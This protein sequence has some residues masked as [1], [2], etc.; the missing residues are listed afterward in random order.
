MY[1]SVVH[2]NKNYKPIPYG[3]KFSSNNIFVNFSNALHTTKILASKNLVFYSRMDEYRFN[4][5]N[6]RASTIQDNTGTTGL[7]SEPQLERM[8]ILRVRIECHR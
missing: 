4:Q 1:V 6:E 7:V 2:F 8:V 5:L 3:Y